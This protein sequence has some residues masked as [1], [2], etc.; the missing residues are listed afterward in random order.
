MFIV[1]VGKFKDDFKKED[2]EILFPFLIAIIIV[3]AI[4]RA[5]MG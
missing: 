1:Y 2:T 5:L 3:L 4:I